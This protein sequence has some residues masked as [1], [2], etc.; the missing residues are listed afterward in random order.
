[1]NGIFRK[2]ADIDRITVDLTK[3]IEQITYDTTH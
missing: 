1:M 2:M 3:V